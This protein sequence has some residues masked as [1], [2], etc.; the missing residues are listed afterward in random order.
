[1]KYINGCINKYIKKHVQFALKVV[2]GRNINN[3][4]TIKKKNISPALS[5]LKNPTLLDFISMHQ[6]TRMGQWR[7]SLTV[8]CVDISLARG[9]IG[10]SYLRKEG[11]ITWVNV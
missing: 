8:A 3:Q 7:V 2:K 9:G 4:H 6:G 1:V 10:R 5:A 11:G